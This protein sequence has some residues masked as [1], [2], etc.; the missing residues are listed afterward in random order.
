MGGI[1][2]ELESQ[3]TCA[4]HLPGELGFFLSVIKNKKNNMEFT[5]GEDFD[6]EVKKLEQW[7][8]QD[9]QPTQHIDMSDDLWLLAPFELIS[10]IKEKDEHI[11]LLMDQIQ[12][13]E[14]FLDCL[15]RIEGRTPEDDEPHNEEESGDE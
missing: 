7:L 11:G 3:L 1:I 8:A 6:N 9:Q 2:K 4:A 12:W 14:D 5:P 10:L 13:H 15:D